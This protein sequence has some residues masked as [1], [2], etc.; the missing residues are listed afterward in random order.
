MILAAGLLGACEKEDETVGMVIQPNENKLQLSTVS[1]DNFEV[2]TT[3]APAVKTSKKYNHVL[4]G[5]LNDSKIGKTSAF[6]ASQYCL[7]SQNVN[8]GANPELISFTAHLDVWKHEGDSLK[9][10]NI[11]VHELIDFD[12]KEDSLYP[13]DTDLSAH[14]GE[15]VANV[16]Y[17]ADTFDVVTFDL[18]STLANKI[19]STASENLVDNESFKEAFK[20]LVF[21][22]DTNFSDLGLIWK[23]NLSSGK[24]F[25]E[26]KYRSLGE[27]GNY[28]TTAFKLKFGDDAGRFNQYLINNSA[29]SSYL[30]YPSDFVYVASPGVARAHINLSPALTLKDSGNLMI[31]KAELVAKGEKT[32]E[33]ISMPKRLLL[34]V[35]NG[36]DADSSITYVDDIA[37]IK[38]TNFDGY[39]N[40]ETGAYHMVI[41]RHLQNLIDGNHSDS[42]LWIVPVNPRTNVHR[43]MLL[44]G[45]NDEK[46]K[47]N[48]TYSKLH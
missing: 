46:I 11:M 13:A 32:E 22:V 5:S 40:E 33:T 36:E 30:N 19:L 39:Y 14:I 2:F 26:L 29:M 20:G 42:L 48:I 3:N 12:I 45:Q 23:F 37:G 21:S 17:T 1:F 31:Y 27:N 47:L 38:T 15:E 24:S 4:L 16:T 18:S 8:F 35:N 7:S 25:I 10:L 28:D 6:F 9:P 44:N 34:R 43:T 41:T